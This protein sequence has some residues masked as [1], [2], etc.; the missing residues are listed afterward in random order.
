MTNPGRKNVSILLR[1]KIRVQLP[2]PL[3]A[4]R[5]YRPE[6]RAYSA[7]GRAYRPEGRAYSSE[8]GG[9]MGD[10]IYQQYSGF[11][12]QVSGFSNRS[13][14]TVSESLMK[15]TFSHRA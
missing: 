14:P 3:P 4:L 13:R 1:V 11:R 8:R 5:A 12:C 10:Y 6:G 7:E 9:D 2:A 15:W